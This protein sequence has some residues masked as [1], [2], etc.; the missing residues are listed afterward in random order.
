MSDNKNGAWKKLVERLKKLAPGLRRVAPDVLEGAGDL[1]GGPAGLALEALARIVAGAG[2]D[3]DMDE[4][5]AA[6]QANPE[7]MVK[8]EELALERERAILQ[9]DTARIESVNATMRV[10]ATGEDKWT[11]RWRPAFGF[12]AAGV[13]GLL[14]TTM[15]VVILCT[16]FGLGEPDV[17]T[18]IGTAFTDMTMF[19]SVALAVLGVSA[20]TR[21]QEKIEAAKGVG[22][23]NLR[24]AQ[25]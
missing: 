9:N 20:W 18:Y 19:W 23:V 21:G 25:N 13:W 22:R 6:I 8:M 11:R 4:V 15:A 7:L 16:S 14:G 3:A 12:I 10:E 5:A 24:N 1:I 2:A 17:I